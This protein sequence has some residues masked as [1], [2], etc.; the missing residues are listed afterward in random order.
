[1]RNYKVIVYPIECEDNTISWGAKIIATGTIGGGDTPDEAVC[2]A[3]KNL[4]YHIE[5]IQKEGKVIPIEDKNTH[6]SGRFQVR[7]S[8]RLH[9]A[10]ANMAKING[11]SMNAYIT[12]AVAWYSGQN[13]SIKLTR[14]DNQI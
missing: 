3:F 13:T 6:Y 11:I 2:E 12:E 1:M 5:A 7:I 10:V 9:E 14:N 8:P 4:E